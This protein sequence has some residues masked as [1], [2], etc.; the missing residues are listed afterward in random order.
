VLKYG[1]VALVGVYLPSNDGKMESRVAH[2]L[3]INK[4]L[5]TAE[6]LEQQGYTISMIGDFNSDNYRQNEFDKILTSR[7]EHTNYSYLDELYVQKADNTFFSRNSKSWIDHI[8]AKPEATT[9]TSVNILVSEDNFGDHHAI[10][11]KLQNKEVHLE[12]KKPKTNKINSKL[13][14]S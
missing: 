10:S 3:E 12:E 1:R 13:W 11:I 6:S 9:I 4:L 7:L 5:S 2:E 14:E 8:I